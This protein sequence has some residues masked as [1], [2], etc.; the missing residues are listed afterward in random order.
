M[1]TISY[2]LRTPISLILGPLEE[3]LA[4]RNERD[5]LSPA[6]RDR[7][8]TIQRNAT[9]LHRYV[10]SLLDYI[11][12]EEGRLKACFR[13]CA[14]GTITASFV[15]AFQSAIDSAGLKLDVSIDPRVD[16]LLA[17][18]S[19]QRRL[20]SDPD[21]WEQ[22]VCNL[23]SNAVK[24][25][26]SGTINVRLELQQHEDEPPKIVFSVADT[27]CG[28]NPAA[29]GRIFQRFYQGPSSSESLSSAAGPSHENF[30]VEDVRGTG[31]GLALTRELVKLHGG[32]IS[33]T[34][35]LN[36]G[37]EFVVTLPLGK[38]HLAPEQIGGAAPAGQPV[39][40]A[41][42]QMLDEYSR[43][44]RE[45][46]VSV[47]HRNNLPEEPSPSLEGTVL[48]VDEAVDTRNVCY[49]LPSLPTNNF[50][51]VSFVF[52]QFLAK[53][54]KDQHLNVV[55][56]RD[57]QDALDQL[58]AVP[59]DLVISEVVLPELSGFELVKRIRSNAE[60]KLTPVILLSA[61]AGKEAQVQG[62]MSGADDYI[63][64][65]FSAKVLLAHVRSQMYAGKAKHE[66][67]QLVRQRA[68]DLAN[69]ERRY[70]ILVQTSPTG[71]VQSELNDQLVRC[72]FFFF[73]FFPPT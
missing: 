59:I 44:D 23:L 6:Q 14:L 53:L 31:I 50:F 73:F 69:S 54:L 65:P 72:L 15:S 52:A 67:N 11:G 12:V 40:P 70:R 1:E 51:V 38:D 60:W 61:S 42:A 16:E 28:I 63:S 30:D 36:R 18:D 29:L 2:K 41:I 17:S 55:L 24:F 19:D 57:G 33:V 62:L 68:A 45:R 71:I 13:P 43:D 34:S 58:A 22:V 5:T 56:A 25:T 3:A 8:L 10:D 39:V 9:R 7:L 21:L 46:R 66:L 32:V 49:V 64:K 26:K 27:G 47:G 48:V 35:E 20:F 4:E 37:S